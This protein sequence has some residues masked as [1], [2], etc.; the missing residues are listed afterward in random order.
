MWFTVLTLHR[1]KND[2]EYSSKPGINLFRHRQTHTNIFSTSPPPPSYPSPLP[3][4]PTLNPIFY[5]PPPQTHPSMPITF[6]SALSSHIQQ[7]LS[8]I[9]GPSR[10]TRR[11]AIEGGGE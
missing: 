11:R 7:P 8:P 5:I 10:P 4:H 2:K 9:P 1:K 6:T 3:Q